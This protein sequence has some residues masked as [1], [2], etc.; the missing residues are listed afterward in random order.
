MEGV[1]KEK[2][3]SRDKRKK[4]RGTRVGRWEGDWVEEARVEEGRRKVGWEKRL[5]YWKRKK[6]VKWTSC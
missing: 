5:R 1:G 6:Y 2:D 3:W 4:R